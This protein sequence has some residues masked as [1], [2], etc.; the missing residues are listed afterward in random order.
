M[1]ILDLLREDGCDPIYM[2][3]TNGGEYKGPCPYC[4]G[5]D[6]FCVW[7]HEGNTGRYW[8][9]QC[10]KQ[11]DAI[12]YLRESRRMT[13]QGARALLG[14]S[15]RW[16][17]LKSREGRKAPWI[18]R[19]VIAPSPT[20]QKKARELIKKTEKHLW[21]SEIACKQARQWL[22]RRGLSAEIIRE[23]NLGWLLEDMWESRSKWGLDDR[24]EGGKRKKLW[25]PSGLVIPYVRG[26]EV[27]RLRIRRPDPADDPKYYLLPG[28][29]T[30]PMLWPP[31]NKI[32]TVVESE[33]D[34]LL[35]RQEISDLAGI[36][37]LGSAQKRPDQ[38][39]HKALSRA[40]LILVALDSDEAGTQATCRWWLRQYEQ[41][42]WWPIPMQYGKDPT[43]AKEAGLDL[44]SWIEA[45]LTQPIRRTEEKH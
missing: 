14:I 39:V 11:G 38:E 4:G 25:I 41:A 29:D 31:E 15:K 1:S 17:G 13:F 44:R 22:K 45:G 7:P 26:E 21:S 43:E 12:Q 27:I 24:I 42:R 32:Y 19:E 40:G 34:G 3:S 23:A 6:R 18:P 30:R 5:E 35:L 10:E 33:L 8:C 36:I 16:V 37:A 2:A 9:R 28:S 20:W